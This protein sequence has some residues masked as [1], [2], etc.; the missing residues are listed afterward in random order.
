MTGS[1]LMESVTMMQS[2]TMTSFPKDVICFSHLR[3][4][5]VFQ[6]PQHL[7]RD[8]P[9]QHRVFYIEEPCSKATEAD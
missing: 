8:A 9:T 3:W 6:R 1:D 2:V 7:M 5:F 4:G